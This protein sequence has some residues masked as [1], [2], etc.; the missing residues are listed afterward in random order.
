[1]LNAPVHT[2]FDAVTDFLA[3]EPSPQEIIG[4]FLPEDLQARLDYLLDKNGEPAM[5]CIAYTTEADAEFSDRFF[6]DFGDRKVLQRETATAEIEGDTRLALDAIE[7]GHHPDFFGNLEE[8]GAA[9]IL[10]LAFQTKV[11]MDYV[12]F[13]GSGTI[14]VEG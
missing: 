8:A 11:A 9:L 2:V 14:Y 3:T 6:R 1:M 5:P 12:D 4:F 13:D 7:A 10:A